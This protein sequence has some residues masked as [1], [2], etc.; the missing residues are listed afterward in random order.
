[1][2]I[3]FVLAIVSFLLTGLSAILPQI[4]VFPIGLATQIGTFM[5]YVYSWEWLFPVSDMM[6][7]FT[8]LIAVLAAEFTYYGSMFIFKIIHGSLRG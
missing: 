3:N 1:M 6:V 4:T 8:I 2:I 7:V 5:N